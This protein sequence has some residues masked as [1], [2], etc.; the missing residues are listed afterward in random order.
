MQFQRHP[1]IPLG[2]GHFQEIDDGMGALGGEDGGTYDITRS[3]PWET[4]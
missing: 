4:S 2:I 1:V 3:R